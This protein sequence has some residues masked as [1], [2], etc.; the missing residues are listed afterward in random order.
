MAVDHLGSAIAGGIWIAE[1]KLLSR[2][3]LNF[4]TYNATYGSLEA[5]I[6]FMIWMW[7]STIVVLLGGEINAAI[8]QRATNANSKKP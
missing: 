2:N 4:G 5:A 6:G 1:P 7:L 3:V 8:E